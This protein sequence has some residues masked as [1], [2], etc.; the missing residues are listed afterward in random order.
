MFETM[1][2][3]N[4]L[5]D[6][7]SRVTSDVDKRE[8]SIIYDALAPCAYQ[9][10][11]TYFNL[12]NYIDLFYANTAVGEYLD[13]KSADYGIERKSSTFAVRQVETTGPVAIGTRWG[14]E[15]TTYRITEL[16]STNVYKAQCEQLGVIGNQYSGTLENIDNV[17]GIT[18]TLTSILTSGTDEETDDSL[19]ARIKTYLTSPSQD[20]NAAQYLKWA[21]EYEG[22]GT[23]KV[24]PLW[25]GGNTVKVAITNGQYLPA[26]AALVEEF[27]N[28]MDPDAAGLGNG[29]AP[30]GSKVTI[31]G[32]TQLGIT[33]S[34][35]VT[36]A[37]GY[38]QADGAADAITDYLASITYIKSSVSYM[39]IG[40]VL[41]DCPSITDLSNLTVNAGTSDVAITG[42][43]I[44]VLTSLTL[45]VA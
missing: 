37:E 5:A 17:G 19:R 32:G 1:T 11:Q 16:I 41:L 6:M 13:R 22:I 20:G 31:T 44:P 28:Y 36:L 45:T 40:S 38:T 26:E 24:F 30:I 10:A 29:V 2:Y 25:N 15:D 43:Y 23:A 14:F 42:D 12:S 4:I 9:L 39:R 33:I 8:G 27:Q 34:G 18:A 3:E 7:L 21:T 35:T